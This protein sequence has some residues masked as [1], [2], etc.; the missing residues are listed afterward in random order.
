MSEEKLS[1]SRKLEIESAERASSEEG[2]LKETY[3]PI[4]EDSGLI[5]GEC[6][7]LN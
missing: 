2:K 6:D 5:H 7:W 4:S 1:S 3:R